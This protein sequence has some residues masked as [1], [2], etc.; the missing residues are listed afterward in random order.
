M[1]E[2][3]N[4]L[5]FNALAREHQRAVYWGFLWRGLALAV[6]S[7]IGGFVLGFIAGAIVGLVGAIAHIER[8]TAI[9]LG[10]VAGGVAGLCW[11]L[12]LLW[13]FLIFFLKARFGP[14]QLRFVLLRDSTGE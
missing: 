4:V 7:V 2:S 10:S 5:P 12:Y 14:Y 3:P 11:G 1:T 13:W 6:C 9:K 8:D